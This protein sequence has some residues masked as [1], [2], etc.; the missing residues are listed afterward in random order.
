MESIGNNCP[1]GHGEM[2][3]QTVSKEADIRGEK[4][5]YHVEC[6]ICP[7]CSLTR[8]TIEQA[9]KAQHAIADAYRVKKG[10]LT[11]PEIKCYRELL[12]LSQQELADKA[13]CSKMSIIRWENGVIQKPI[14]DRSLRDI[15]CPPE[16]QD[17]YTGNREF[18]LGRI[19]LVYD[20]FGKWVDY[21]LLAHGDM[22][23]YAA[24]NCWYADLVAF[25]ELGKGI[26][27]AS[28]AVMRHGPQLD[29]YAELVEEILK[30]DSSALEPLSI[31]EAEI[32]K[33]L[34]GIF[35][36]RTDAYKASHAEPVW[37]SIEKNIGRGISYKIAYEL[38]SV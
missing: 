30:I 33:R 24:K 35:R 4:I 10:L 12:G 26:T 17:E 8:T 27:G 20:E 19:K 21:E 29:N 18:S 3:R 37:K 34:S 31:E 7:E 14:S 11:G 1:L 16:L 28:Y 2:R 38:T 9:A 25:R 5:S 6:M 15:L 32:I 36:K 23:L 22:G 13:A